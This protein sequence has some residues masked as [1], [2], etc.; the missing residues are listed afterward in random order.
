[1]TAEPQ[2]LSPAA[3]RNLATISP[4]P[5]RGIVAVSVFVVV[6]LLLAAI[7]FLPV[8]P[9]ELAP[10]MLALGPLVIALAIA[11]WEGNG[12]LG[13][14]WQMLTKVPHNVLWFLAIAVPVAW[15]LTVLIVAIFTGEQ[16][17][18]IFD[19]VGLSSLLV[20]LVVLI[21]AFAEELAW[22]GFAVPRLLPFMSP[23]V[24][25]LLLVVP[26]TILHLPLTLVPGGI[27]EELAVFPGVLALFSYSVILTWIFVGSGGSVLLVALVHAGLNGVVPI[28]QNLDPD[29]AWLLRA[30]VAAVIAILVVLFGDV[31]RRTSG[32]VDQAS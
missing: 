31:R 22:R 10:F 20:F 7:A 8:V 24:A 19:G 1:M 14:L 29:Q 16:T 21:P 15:A 12:A 23:L 32:G 3:S 4:D 28:F 2:A 6:C 9:T 17:E 13:R 30:I 18:G 27:N 25:A 5:R 11:W 26:W